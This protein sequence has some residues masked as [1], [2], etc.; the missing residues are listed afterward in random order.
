MVDRDGYTSVFSSFL[1]LNGGRAFR[2]GSNRWLRR[3]A[4]GLHQIFQQAIWEQAGFGMSFPLSLVAR[5]SFDFSRGIPAR[6]VHVRFGSILG[7]PKVEIPYSEE[8]GENGDGVG[9]HFKGIHRTTRH[10]VIGSLPQVTD[11]KPP[12]VPTAGNDTVIRAY[13]VLG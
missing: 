6:L 11:S 5:R 9:M 10:E 12:A 13:I 8:S 3:R 2:G 4:M 7:R 1:R